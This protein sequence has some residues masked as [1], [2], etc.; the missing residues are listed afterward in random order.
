MPFLTFDDL[1]NHVKAWLRDTE[2]PNL[3]AWVQL[4]IPALG[5]RS[6]F[7]VASDTDGES[8]L[9]KFCLRVKCGIPYSVA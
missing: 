7:Q 9:A 8:K 1:P 4:P 3:E 5:G 6:I 2:E